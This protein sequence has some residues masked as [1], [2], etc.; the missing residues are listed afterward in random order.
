VQGRA[1]LEGVAIGSCRAMEEIAV[2]VE[3]LEAWLV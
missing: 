3:H 2:C 1:G